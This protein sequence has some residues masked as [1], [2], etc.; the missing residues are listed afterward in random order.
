M[1]KKLLLAV[2]LMVSLFTNAQNIQL[3]SNAEISVL[4]IGPGLNLEDSFGHSGFRIKDYTI[5]RVYDYGRY[6]FDAPNFLLKFAQGKLNYK[7]GFN[8]FSDFYNHYLRKNRT[9]EEQVL[10]LSQSQKQHLFDFLVN[11]EKPKNRYYL[12]DFFYDNCASIIRDVITEEI[13]D[14]VVFNTPANF[15]PQTFRELIRTHLNQNSWGSLGI[16]LA[17][18]SVI[19]RQ[20][21][22]EEHMFLPHYIYTFFKSANYKI[23][24]KPLVK[25]NITLFKSIET[26]KTSNFISSPLAVFGLL[27]I[28]I[29]WIT[30]KDYKNNKRNRILDVIL[31]SITGAIGIFILLLWFATDHTATAQNYN[32]LWAFAINIFMLKQVWKREAKQWFVKYVKFLILALCLLTLHWAIGVQRFAIGFSPL[33]IALLVRYVF[34]LKH[35]KMS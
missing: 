8:N 14:S 34:L 27:S 4:T 29:L 5:D 21:T 17:L 13:D 32:L 16:D 23:S 18:G 22:P 11:N 19:D 10:N 33:F 24:G 12:Y 7:L 26:Q 9:I 2:F 31:F 6:D 3:S 28:I 25:E 30:Y 1:Y 20:A 35:Y 15:K